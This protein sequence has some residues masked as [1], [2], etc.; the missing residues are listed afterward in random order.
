MLPLRFMSQRYRDNMLSIFFNI[1][2]NMLMW[3]KFTLFQ[4]LV[5]DGGKIF[6][7]KGISN[8][9]TFFLQILYKV[10]FF[11]FSKYQICLQRY[12]MM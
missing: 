11:I 6:V 7:E 1:K 9:V 12:E 8:F 2:Y 5:K 3:K 4:R 10:T